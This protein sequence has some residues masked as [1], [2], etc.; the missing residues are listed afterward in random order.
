MSLQKAG[1]RGGRDLAPE[2]KAVA[3][4]GQQRPERVLV[5]SPLRKSRG[6]WHLGDQYQALGYQAV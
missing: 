3:G 1:G 6:E 2:P 4:S 5:F